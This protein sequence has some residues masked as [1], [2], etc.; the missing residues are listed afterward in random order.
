MTYDKNYF[1]SKWHQIKGDVKLRWGRLTDDDLTQT[2]GVEEKII[3]K[4]QEAYHLS[5]NEAK[6][7]VE[8]F[9][10]ELYKRE[11]A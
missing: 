7:D 9:K 1:E 11:S 5:Y 4:L 3:G 6:A 2:E 8:N 10:N